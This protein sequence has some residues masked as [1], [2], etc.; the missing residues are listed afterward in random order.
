MELF[1]LIAGGGEPEE[2]DPA[3]RVGEQDGVPS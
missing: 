3:G 1:C 2:A